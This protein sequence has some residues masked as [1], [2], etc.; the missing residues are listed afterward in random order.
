MSGEA[1]P[2]GVLLAR[3]REAKALSQE[4]LARRAG[5][6]P[7]TINRLETGGR[8]PKKKTVQSLIAALRLSDADA[9]ALA[10]SAAPGPRPEAATSPPLPVGG[11]SSVPLLAPS[12]SMALI[13]REQE[14][15][16]VASRLG[17][18]VRL[19]LLVGPGGVGKTRVARAA[20]ADF[21]ARFAADVRTVELAPL[22]EAGRAQPDAVARVAAAVARARADRTAGLADDGTPLAGGPRAGRLL[23]VLENF[24]PLTAAG[25]LLAELLDNDPALTL[26]VT[27][28]ARLHLPAEHEYAIEP[29]DAPTAKALF[30][31]RM[32][33][34]GGIATD[35]D[36]ATAG[37]ICELLGH[38]PLAIELAAA[39]CV[40]FTPRDVLELLGRP[41]QLLV[42]G[43]RIGPPRQWTLRD[44][45]AW[46]DT[47]LAPDERAVFRRLAAFAGGGDLAATEAVCGPVGDPVTGVANALAVLLTASLVR[48]ASAAGPAPRYAMLAT[49]HEYAAEQLAANGEEAAVRRRHAGHFLRLAER[50]STGDEAHWRAALAREHDNVHAALGWATGADEADLA[51]RLAAALADYWLARG[52]LHEG[53]RRLRWALALTGGAPLARAWALAGAAALAVAQGDA[54]AA[55]QLAGEALPPVRDA[56][57][58]PLIAALLVHLGVAA[59]QLADYPAAVAALTE[60]LDRH[61]AMGDGRGAIV[62]TANLAL[63]AALRGDFAGA[64]AA[65]PVAGVPALQSASHRERAA[66]NYTMGEVLLRRGDLAPAHEAFMAAEALARDAGDEQGTARAI[67]AL[68]RVALAAGDDARAAPLL[69]EGLSRRE[70]LGDWP[71]VV[72]DMIGIGTVAWRQ[73]DAAEAVW[74]YRDALGLAHQIGDRLGLAVA[75]ERLAAVTAARSAADPATGERAARLLG[76]AAALREALGAPL[77]PIDRAEHERA[78]AAARGALG[79]EGFAAAFAA[80][81]ELS[82]A[83]II[84]EAG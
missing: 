47:L 32:A 11:P 61:T 55:R 34:D 78:I 53:R 38:L 48:Q 4:N 74:R 70:N 2:F 46:S 26:L 58:E 40:R 37:E 15:D 1:E 14:R 31:A 73:G 45:I 79:A 75:A 18:G 16:E 3:F 28:R 81:R 64:L 30:R 43:S 49:I 20:A 51:L 63:V 76:A 67:A 69:E 52:F 60:A 33:A 41:L 17:R 84:A 9:D 72:A 80:G 27:S 54:V 22:R 65:L 57:D 8:P 66:L 39:R 24:E 77:P 56:G 62:A 6:H 83:G 10:A 50:G 7:K 29:F 68:G 12:F 36:D 82:L 21:A 35:E 42:D 19:L 44:T 59:R 5:L 23:L 25:P 71:G 13:D